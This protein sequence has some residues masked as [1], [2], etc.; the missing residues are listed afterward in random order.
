MCPD[1]EPGVQSGEVTHPG[2]QSHQTVELEF[3]FRFAGGERGGESERKRIEGQCKSSLLLGIPVA[4]GAQPSPLAAWSLGPGFSPRLWQERFLGKGNRLG[5]QRPREG[6]LAN[7]TGRSMA[8]PGLLT[9]GSCCHPVLPGQ[10]GAPGGGGGSSRLC[11]HLNRVTRAGSRARGR[12]ILTLSLAVHSGPRETRVLEGLG[13][14][15]KSK[16][17]FLQRGTT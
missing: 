9:A 4:S 15:G 2:A 8:E 17:A 3:V 1:K 5:E 7:V 11:G 6:Q 10:G 12:S 16:G 14:R 13:D